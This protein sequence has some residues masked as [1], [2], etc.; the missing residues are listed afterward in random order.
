VNTD[1]LDDLIHDVKSK[2]TSLIG[3]AALLK[4]STEAE[5]KEL[6]ELMKR[7]AKELAQRLE[8]P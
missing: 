2:C 8:R 1:P 6:L 5:K 7:S 4:K 3:A